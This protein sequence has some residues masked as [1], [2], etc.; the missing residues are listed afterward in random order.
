MNN[1]V[2]T[3]AAAVED[4]GGEEDMVEITVAED[5]EGMEPLDHSDQPQSR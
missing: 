2:A 3:G 5:V 1:V 4:T